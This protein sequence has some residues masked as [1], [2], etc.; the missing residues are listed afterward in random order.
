MGDIPEPERPDWGSLPMSPEARELY[1]SIFIPSIERYAKQIERTPLSILVWGPA[2]GGGKLYDKRLQ[3]RGELRKRGMA[4]VFSEEICPVGAPVSL[5]ETEML[6]AMAADFIII[7][8]GSPGSIGEAHDFSNFLLTIGRKM[9]IFIDERYK[10]G[11]S[12]QGALQELNALY[13]NVE[14]FSFPKDIDECHLLGS[15]LKKV[16]VLQVAKWRSSL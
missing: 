7:I 15:V 5:K 11:Y 14:T 1:E 16:H 4:A 9:L 3:I 10:G 6:Q 8:Q 12:F 13:G 2:Q